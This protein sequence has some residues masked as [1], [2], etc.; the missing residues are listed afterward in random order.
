MVRTVVASFLVVGHDGTRVA[1][2]AQVLARVEA[3][4]RDPARAGGD[5]VAGRTL[6][7]GRILHNGHAGRNAGR[8]AST[9]ACWPYR[10]TG[11]DRL[12]ARRHRGERGGRVDQVRGRVAVHEHDARPDTGDRFGRRDEGVRGQDRLVARPDPDGPQRQFQRIGA[13]R[14]RRR[15]AR[16]R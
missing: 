14:R 5:P 4:G 1:V 9:G 12:G 7:L 3:G 11:Q 10:C 8:S 2:G 16:R 13:V 6:A 15:S